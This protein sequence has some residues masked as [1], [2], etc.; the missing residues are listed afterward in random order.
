[1]SQPCGPRSA[2]GYFGIDDEVVAFMAGVM[3]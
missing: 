3:R 1:M 2:H